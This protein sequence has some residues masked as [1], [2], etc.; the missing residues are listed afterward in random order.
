MRL[1]NADEMLK[2]YQ[3]ICEEVSCY[4]CSFYIYEEP[5]V[6]WCRLRNFIQNAET[7]D[8]VPVV[9]CKDCNHYESCGDTGFCLLVQA[10]AYPDGFCAWA[11][12]KSE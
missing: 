10:G 8:A 9:R 7:I 5:S 1:I 6:T 4:E 12:R 2:N 3:D 11:E